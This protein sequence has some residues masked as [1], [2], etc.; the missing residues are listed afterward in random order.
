[1]KL[2]PLSAILISFT[3][4]TDMPRCRP[5]DTEAKL[6]TLGNVLYETI[7]VIIMTNIVIETMHSIRG[8]TELIKQNSYPKVN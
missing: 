2:V 4:G 3:T 6:S 5:G 1:M 7:I 8:V